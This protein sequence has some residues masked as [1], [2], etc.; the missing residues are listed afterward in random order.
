[1]HHDRIRRGQRQLL[2]GEAVAL[3]VL[4]RGRQQRAV[5]PFVLQSQ[6]HDH[7]DAVEALLHVGVDRHAHLLEPARQQRARADHADLVEERRGE[8]EMGCGAA[9]HPVT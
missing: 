8:R 6:H 7:V 2:G 9:Q 5:H 1:M 4:V 3:E